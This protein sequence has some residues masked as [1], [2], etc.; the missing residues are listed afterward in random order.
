MYIRRPCVSLPR[1][2]GLFTWVA[3]AVVAWAVCA[4]VCAHTANFLWYPLRSAHIAPLPEMHHCCVARAVPAVCQIT[5]NEK[6]CPKVRYLDSFLDKMIKLELPDEYLVAGGKRTHAAA[7]AERSPV[8]G[9]CC[10]LGSSNDGVD[11]V[12]A[13]SVSLSALHLRRRRARSRGSS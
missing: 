9:S 13:L 1:I 8:P 10:V 2:R 11:R 12:V 5:I 7:L 3:L 6:P 4:C